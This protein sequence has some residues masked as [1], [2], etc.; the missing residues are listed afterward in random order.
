V[1]LGLIAIRGLPP[2]SGAPWSHAGPCAHWSQ[3]C[4]NMAA[5]EQVYHPRTRAGKDRS[6]GCNRERARI[7]K[8]TRGMAAGPWRPPESSVFAARNAGVT[9]KRSSSCGIGCPFRVSNPR[10][11]RPHWLGV[12]ALPLA[13]A[14]TVRFFL[15]GSQWLTIKKTSR[16]LSSSSTFL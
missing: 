6:T 3:S 15:H 11:Y 12:P 4:S 9:A 2:R 16:V 5:C 1:L 13:L 8:A 7:K 10:K 14:S